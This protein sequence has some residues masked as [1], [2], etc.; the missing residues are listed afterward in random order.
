MCVCVCGQLASH[1]PTAQLAVG[2]LLWH[3][4]HTTQLP[5]ICILSMSHTVGEGPGSNLKLPN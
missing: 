1:M 5:C 4:S 2:R 3:G